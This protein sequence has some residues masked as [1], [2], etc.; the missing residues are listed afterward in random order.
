MRILKISCCFCTCKI[1]MLMSVHEVHSVKI[2]VSTLFQTSIE[3]ELIRRNTFLFLSN[4]PEN[5]ISECDWMRILK[6]SCCFCTCK[7]EMLMSV[8]WSTPSKDSHPTL[9][10]TSIEHELTRRNTFLFLSNRSENQI[11][12]CDWMRILKISC[13]F[14]TCKI[15]MLKSVH[16]VH[17]VK[18]V[19]PRSFKHL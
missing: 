16:E 3:H 15:E 12:E 18:I 8:T 17:S 11:S 7:I 4:G 1:E 6:I 5:Q 10:Q 9:F 13:C 19:V 2:V 14:C